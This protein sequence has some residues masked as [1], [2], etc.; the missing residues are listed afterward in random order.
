M[1]PAR[2]PVNLDPRVGA[3]EAAQTTRPFSRGLRQAQG[4]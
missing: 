2:A 4:H 1:T 3:A